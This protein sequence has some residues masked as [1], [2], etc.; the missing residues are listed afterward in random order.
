MPTSSE[1]RSTARPD[2]ET[3]PTA[4]RPV[5]AG[6]PQH[7]TK[8]HNAAAQ[9]DAA[10][11][12]GISIAIY[13]RLY[14]P[15]LCCSKYTVFPPG[16]PLRCFGKKTPYVFSAQPGQAR[17]TSSGLNRSGGRRSRTAFWMSAT[18]RLTCQAYAGRWRSIR[19][20]TTRPNDAE[21]FAAMHTDRHVRD[22]RRFEPCSDQIVRIDQTSRRWRSGLSTSFVI[23]STSTR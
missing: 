2:A 14:D 23:P 12:I 21:E 19:R 10:R 22:D 4:R 20:Q 15:S 13:S 9:P 3:P 18:N 8:L 7:R 17:R 16:L 11:H 6:V 1:S 5:G